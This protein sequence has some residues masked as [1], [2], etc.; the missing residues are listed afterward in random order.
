MSQSQFASFPPKLGLY[1]PAFE[2]DACGV[3][4]IAQIKG[5]KTHDIVS[6]ALTMLEH[7]DHRGA[8]GCEEN[9]GDG[10]GILTALPHDFLVKA[11]LKDAQIK[12]PEQGRYGAGI[13][14]LPTDTEQ[15]DFV[16]QYC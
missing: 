6:G 4:F 8:C 16:I 5:K 12:L 13:V 2:H 14:F 1:D 3:G 10:A 15:R 7:M 11:A 9:T